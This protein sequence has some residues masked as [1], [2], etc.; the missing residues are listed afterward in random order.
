MPVFRYEAIDKRGRNLSGMMPA[1]DESNLE[2]KLKSAGFWLI[3]AATERPPAAMDK[4]AQSDLGWRTMWGKR[5]RRALIDF[6]TLMSFQSKVGIPLVQALEVASQDCED[7]QFR[8]VLAGLQH[9]IES[10]LLFYEALEKY[11]RLF[12]PHFVSVIRA[13]EMSSKLPETFDDL[14]EYLEWV[15]QVIAEMRQASLYPLIVTTVIFAF[16][17]FL[18][19]FIIPRFATLLTSLKIPLPLLT[20]I[21]FALSDFVKATWWLWLLGLLAVTLG[22]PLGRRLS[23]RFALWLDRLKLNLP[24][25]GPLNLMLALSRF[26]HNFAIL[27]RAGIPILQSLNLCQGLVGSLVVEDAVAGVHED[28]KTGST[29]S[30]ALRR[31]PIFPPMLLRMVVMGETTGN[32]DAA[33]ENVSEYYNEIIPRRIKKIFT[34]LEPALMLALIFVVG[35]VALSIY[36]PSLALMGNIR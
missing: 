10:G 25:F 35:A 1:L 18:F 5:R 19:T 2:L 31:Q 21:I 11:P 13:G 22:V 29:I 20:Q 28:V 34:V 30:E 27:Y 12:T 23:R 24:I 32:L 9:H 6:C 36:L 33:L 8:R 17:L 4:P 14:R 3:D 7:V 26:T 16:V 15:D